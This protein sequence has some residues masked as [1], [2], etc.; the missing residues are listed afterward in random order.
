MAHDA[1]LHVKLNSLTD[2]KLAK[3]AHAREKSKGQLVREAIAA[4]YQTA[5]DEMPLSQRQALAAYQ[6]G[7]IS[8]AKLAKV[9][10]LHVLALRQWMEEHGIPQLNAYGDEDTAHA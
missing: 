2:E 8:M 4:C 1:T 3:L 9:M 10:G 6:G 5:L 7:Y